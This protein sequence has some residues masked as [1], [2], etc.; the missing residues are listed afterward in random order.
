MSLPYENATS[1]QK[2]MDEIQKLLRGFGCG[3]F[4]TGEDFSSGELFVQFEYKGRN[5]DMRV[6]A[7]GY[8]AAWLK[9][10]PFNPSRHRLT[11]AQHEATALE[12]ASIATYSILLDWVKGQ[13][14]AVEIGMM[15]FEG[16]FLSHLMLPSG[17]RLIDHV[18]QNNI[19]PL[20]PA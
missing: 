20:P 10:H 17:V 11:R 16:A 18:T 14:T 9:H 19:L 7:K 8:A 13:L 4:A 3:R 5:V 6:S 1:G 12:I 2:A 15:S